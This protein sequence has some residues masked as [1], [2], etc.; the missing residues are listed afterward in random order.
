MLM[1]IVAVFVTVATDSVHTYHV[2]LVG[3]LSA[4]LVFTT[5][6]VNSLIYYSDAAKEAAAAGFILLS[7]VSVSGDITPFKLAPANNSLDRMDLLLRFAADSI[8][9]PHTR[10]LRLAQ[11]GC[12]FAKQ[13][14]HDPAL[15]P[16]R[17]HPLQQP[18]A[19]N[20]QRQPA[21]GL[22]DLVTR[23]RLRRRRSRPATESLG[24]SIPSTSFHTR[25]LSARHRS[26]GKPPADRVRLPVPREGDLQLRSEPRRQQRGVFLQA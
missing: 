14:L 21:R 19:A 24:I 25:R 4:G 16:T 15:S 2:A 10:L 8:A 6:S 7:M 23:D 17:H 1:C 22:R 26:R 12:A 13:P 3:L 20:V 18:P 5:S 11:R 9:P